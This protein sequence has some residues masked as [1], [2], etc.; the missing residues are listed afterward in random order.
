MFVEVSFFKI[1]VIFPSTPACICALLLTSSFT[2][3]YASQDAFSWLNIEQFQQQACAFLIVQAVYSN[4]Y[5]GCIL[6]LLLE[7]NSKQLK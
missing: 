3:C 5:Q 7:I 2:F 6:Q 4:S 1:Y